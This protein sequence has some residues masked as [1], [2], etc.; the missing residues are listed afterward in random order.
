MSGVDKHKPRRSHFYISTD[1]NLKKTE[2][3]YSAE[4]DTKAG[5]ES[6]LRYS[7]RLL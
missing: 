1:L 3:A 7:T 6:S 4:V 2:Q 5:S